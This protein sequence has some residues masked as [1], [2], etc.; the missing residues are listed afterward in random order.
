[1]CVYPHNV[2]LFVGSDTIAEIVVITRVVVAWHLYFRIYACFYIQYAYTFTRMYTFAHIAVANIIRYRFRRKYPHVYSHVKPN[3][4][5]NDSRSLFQ[6]IR[7]AQ[8]DH[9]CRQHTFRHATRK[10]YF[11][12]LFSAFSSGRPTRIHM[13]LVS[14]TVGNECKKNTHLKVYITWSYN[15]G[16]IKCILAYVHYTYTVKSQSCDV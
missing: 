7:A 12:L 3:Y 8:Y 5:E 10:S 11:R 14:L 6:I 1:M 16:F 4:T 2:L 15:D 9:M 13:L